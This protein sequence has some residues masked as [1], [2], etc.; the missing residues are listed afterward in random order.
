VA[1][2]EVDLARLIFVFSYFYVIIVL[3]ATISM[4]IMY[5]FMLASL[6]KR[7]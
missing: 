1:V 6:F 7:L 3:F 2:C 4:L 5:I